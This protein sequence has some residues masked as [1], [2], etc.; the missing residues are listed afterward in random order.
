MTYSAA[1]FAQVGFAQSLD[2]QLRPRGIKVSAFWPGGMK[3]EFALGHVRAEESV[4]RLL[5]PA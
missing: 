4:N 1:K 2:M 5:P 3:T